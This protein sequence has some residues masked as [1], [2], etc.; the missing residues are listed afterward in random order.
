M[1]TLRQIFEELDTEQMDILKKIQEISLQSDGLKR[2]V[3]ELNNMW[4]K[5]S[6]ND[7]EYKQRMEELNKQLEAQKKQAEKN[8]LAQTAIAQGIKQPEQPIV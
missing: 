7:A 3:I 4:K 1:K 6:I 8:K 5:K 2:Q